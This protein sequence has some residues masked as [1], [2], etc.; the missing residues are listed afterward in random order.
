M[1]PHEHDHSCHWC[2]G[3]EP[4]DAPTIHEALAPF[5]DDIPHL[6]TDDANHNAD[7]CDHPPGAERKMAGGNHQALERQR[8]NHAQRH[9]RSPNAGKNPRH[10]GE[11]GQARSHMFVRPRGRC[12]PAP[13]PNDWASVFDWT[14]APRGA[15][16]SAGRLRAGDL[17]FVR[18]IFPSFFS[19]RLLSCLLTGGLV[20][21]AG[22]ACDAALTTEEVGASDSALVAAHRVNEISPHLSARRALLTKGP[23]SLS[24]DEERRPTMGRNAGKVECTPKTGQ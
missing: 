17:R 18:I 13:P 9:H 19:H 2:A 6:C 5:K 10:M 16:S 23:D 14:I 11:R 15:A 4:L 1:K 8:D 22:D 24:P 12:P 21:I 20:E 7:Q 3:D